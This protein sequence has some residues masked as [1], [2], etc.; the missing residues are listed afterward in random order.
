[1]VRSGDRCDSEE[2]FEFVRA[3]QACYAVITVCRVLEVSASGYHAWR[4]RPVWARARRRKLKPSSDFRNEQKTPHT[5]DSF[6]DL[7]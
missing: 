7:S 3:H 2:V 6:H 5:P 1:M 4:K